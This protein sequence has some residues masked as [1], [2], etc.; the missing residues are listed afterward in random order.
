MLSHPS[1]Q[2]LFNGIF[3]PAEWWTIFDLLGWLYLQKALD[4]TISEDDQEDLGVFLQCREVPEIRSIIL[5]VERSGMS[6]TTHRKQ[7]SPDITKSRLRPAIN[8]TLLL[9]R[10]VHK[11]LSLAFANPP[12]PDVRPAAVSAFGRWAQNG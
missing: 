1:K 7:Y 3:K 6:S 9:E 5:S 12:Y 2:S 8:A 10:D 4:G 11:T